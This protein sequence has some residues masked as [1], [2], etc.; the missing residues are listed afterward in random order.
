MCSR[1]CKSQ[2][3]LHP[4]GW[5]RNGMNRLASIY[6]TPMYWVIN[7]CLLALKPADNVKHFKCYKCKQKRISQQQGCI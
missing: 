4:Y 3:F 6:V 5:K 1:H 2:N 7:T